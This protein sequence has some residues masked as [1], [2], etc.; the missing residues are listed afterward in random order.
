MSCFLDDYRPYGH[1][2]VN[3]NL[4]GKHKDT[5]GTKTQRKAGI[6]DLSIPAFLCVF[7]PF[8]SLCFKVSQ[9]Q[10]SLSIVLANV[11]ED[12]TTSHPR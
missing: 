5:K 6:N 7:V 9:P 10:A 1:P 2:N 8:V 3:E 4:F 11:L 12:F